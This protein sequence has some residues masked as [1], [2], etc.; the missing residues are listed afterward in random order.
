MKYLLPIFL[1]TGCATQFKSSY[2]VNVIDHTRSIT[3]YEIDAIVDCVAET[4]GDQT[5]RVQDL[6]LEII[7][8]QN[9]LHR[10]TATKSMRL[11]GLFFCRSTRN[12]RMKVSHIGGN[13]FGKSA[14]VHELLHLYR[15]Q[16]LGSCDA[17]HDDDLFWDRSKARSYLNIG[18][19]CAE[20]VLC[21]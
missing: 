18:L 21:K 7:S 11:R 2:G 5:D 10:K 3:T 15:E 9:W 19:K 17:N 12:L 14:F 4:L 13:C 16:T 20:E 1:L 6:K 8:G